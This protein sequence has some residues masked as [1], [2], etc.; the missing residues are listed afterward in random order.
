MDLAIGK[1]RWLR[2]STLLAAVAV[3]VSACGTSSTGTGENIKNGGTLI[4][5]LDA[6]A[7]FDWG[8]LDK[9]EKVDANTVKFTLKDIF[10]PFQAN[11][12]LTFVA[13]ASVYGKIDPAKQRT[14]PV[15]L[16]PTVTGGPY[17][18]DK[19]VA[20]SEIDYVANTNYYLGRPHY[21]KVIA[22]VITD[23][24]AGTNALING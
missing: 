24:T 12:L 11:N 8:E 18:F 16:N 9:V 22:K 3:L 2:V 10:A 15:S 21:D 19:R 6:D 17:K 13:P 4:W 23:A 20:G 1:S 7:A 5:A 14:D